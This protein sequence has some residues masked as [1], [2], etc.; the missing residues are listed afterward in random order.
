MQSG[1]N[2]PHTKHVKFK[3]FSLVVDCYSKQPGSSIKTLILAIEKRSYGHRS[4]LGNLHCMQRA[5]ER[6][7]ARTLESDRDRVGP[8]EGKSYIENKRKTRHKEHN[9]H[10]LAPNTN[11]RTHTD[12]NSWTVDDSSPCS[13]RWRRYVC[14]SSVSNV[15]TLQVS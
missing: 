13:L 9:D 1:T 6:A 11:T 12:T 4:E 2:W 5:C 10:G 7:R 15:C 14:L 3:R 8:G